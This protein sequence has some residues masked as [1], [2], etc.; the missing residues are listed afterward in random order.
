MKKSLLFSFICLAV[1]YLSGCSLLSPKDYEGIQGEHYYLTKVHFF[2]KGATQA[3]I[4]KLM[5][6]MQIPKVMVLLEHKYGI[7]VDYSEFDLFLY[8]KD[9]LKIRA[10]GLISD[11]DFFWESAG[12]YPNKIEIDVLLTEV[13]ATNFDRDYSITIKT[14]NSVKVR[15]RGSFVADVPAITEVA[16]RLNYSKKPACDDIYI[17]K[18]T[19][20][21]I[22]LFSKIAQKSSPEAAAERNYLLKSGEVKAKVRE[23]YD[24]FSP[25]ERERY[26]KDMRDY[27]DELSKTK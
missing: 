21:E 9:P 8:N 18:S 24:G 3:S 25:A 11:N 17:N 6:D 7:S 27:L 19:K 4:F 12:Q 14:E 1:L 22:D 26:I 5:N 15:V 2:R 13:S 23:P 10:E 20:E 16:S